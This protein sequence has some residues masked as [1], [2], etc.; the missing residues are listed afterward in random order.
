[1]TVNDEHKCIGMFHSVGVFYTVLAHVLHSA[2]LVAQCRQEL[3]L[4]SS[5]YRVAGSPGCGYAIA[6]K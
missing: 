1:M 5:W 3:T 2:L 6:S 4:I